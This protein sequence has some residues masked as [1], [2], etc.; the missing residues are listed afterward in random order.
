MKTDILR[1]LHLSSVHVKCHNIPS[2]PELTENPY[3]KL[4]NREKPSYLNIKVYSCGKVQN[5]FWV[6]VDAPCGSG[7][8]VNFALSWVGFRRPIVKTV[9]GVGAASRSSA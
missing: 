7:I 2:L 3:P 4:S 1:K 9:S 5:F 8:G 6:T